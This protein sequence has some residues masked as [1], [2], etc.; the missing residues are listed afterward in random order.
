MKLKTYTGYLITLALLLKRKLP[1]YPSPYASIDTYTVYLLFVSFRPFQM[2][3]SFG[4]V[5]NFVDDRL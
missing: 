5:T 3:Q 4:D 1:E 2:F